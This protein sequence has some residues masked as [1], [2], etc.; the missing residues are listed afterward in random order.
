LSN[1]QFVSAVK[2]SLAGTGKDEAVSY[3]PWKHRGRM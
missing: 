1:P 3:R 2:E